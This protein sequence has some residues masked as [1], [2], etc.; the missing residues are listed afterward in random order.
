MLSQ[1]NRVTAV[2][3]CCPTC[4]SQERQV[5]NGSSNGQPLKKCQDCRRVYL[6]ETRE[7]GYNP[8]TRLEAVRLYLD[9]MNLRRIGRILG[10]NHQSVANW[11]KA[12]HERLQA[13]TADFPNANPAP[14]A[15]ATQTTDE[16]NV[17]ASLSVVEGDEIFTF[18]GTKK[19]ERTS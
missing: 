12:H 10:V 16:K 6:V 9:G 18:I 1:R 5:K 3:D 11:V 2:H 8:E 17:A 4:G 19:S 7:R 13:K 15:M 14:A